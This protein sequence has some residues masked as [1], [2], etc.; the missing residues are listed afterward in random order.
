MYTAI[1]PPEIVAMPPTINASSSD[2]VMS[3]TYG[4]T[5]IG[6][7]VCPMNTF[8]AAESV[9]APLVFNAY[10]MARAISQTMNW[11]MPK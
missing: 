10:I 3:G 7:S 6:A 8:A 11:R 1:T 2:R 4:L 9:S 5:M